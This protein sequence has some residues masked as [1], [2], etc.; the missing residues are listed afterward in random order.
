MY[1]RNTN[2]LF[3]YASTNVSYIGIPSSSSSSSLYSTILR[4]TRGYSSNPSSFLL[5]RCTTTVNTS[6]D[7]CH[8]RHRW[9]PVHPW[10]FTVS[11]SPP[12]VLFSTVSSPSSSSSSSSGGTKFSSSSTTSTVELN[13]WGIPKGS[14]FDKIKYAIRE[15]GKTALIVYGTLWIVPFMATYGI[16]QSMNNFHQDPVQLIDWIMGIETRIKIWTYCHLPIDEPLND[17][18]IS[19]LYAYIASELIETPRLLLTL[20]ISPKIKQWWYTPVN[21]SNSGN[22]NTANIRID[23]ASV[24]EASTSTARINK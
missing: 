16:C 10:L 21:S 6:V 2:R 13:A 20:Y 22:S 7:R 15:Y 4:S 19:L 14:L 23:P 8:R 11:S 17:K 18:T 12:S 24:S 9:F 5:P 1:N 3:R